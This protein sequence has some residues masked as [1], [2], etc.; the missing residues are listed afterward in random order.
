MRHVD[1]EKVLKQSFTSKWSYAIIF[2]FSFFGLEPKKSDA[3][4]WSTALRWYERAKC[5]LGAQRHSATCFIFS[6][7]NH[8][9]FG[10]L[11]RQGVAAKQGCCGWST[12]G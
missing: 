10:G 3:V 6:L 8:S 5:R 4:T 12:G 7:R 11:Q 1:A 9:L 2:F